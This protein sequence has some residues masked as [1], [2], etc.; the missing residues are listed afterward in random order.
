M[1]KTTEITTTDHA[2]L[3]AFL[4]GLSMG[5]FDADGGEIPVEVLVG[6][7]RFVKAGKID[8]SDPV[9][10]NAN[11]AA[12][13]LVFIDEKELKALKS[14]LK[15]YQEL[16]IEYQREARMLRKEL[17]ARGVTHESEFISK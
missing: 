7:H 3:R 16:K 11:I 6:S 8:L 2:V 1:N 10:C 9:Q 4:G 14:S 15:N 13:D 5:A 12:T 17:E